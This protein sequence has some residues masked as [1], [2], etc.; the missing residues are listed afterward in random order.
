MKLIAIFLII[1]FSAVYGIYFYTYSAPFSQEQLGQLGDFAGGNLNPILTFISVLALL[2]TISLQTRATELTKDAQELAY[3][4][5]ELTRKESAD[6]Q[7]TIKEQSKLVA[8]QIF[9]SSFFNLIRIGLD[10]Y[11][12]VEI[13]TKKTNLK[14][15]K[16]YDAIENKFQKLKSS[17]QNQ[18]AAFEALDDYNG[19]ICYTAIKNFS[20]VFRFIA[21]N[22]PEDSKEKYTSIALSLL[23]T[24]LMYILCIAKNHTNWAIL[25]S[26]EKCSVFTKKGITDLLD[27]YK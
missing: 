17:G 6:A 4:E 10:E 27:G 14:G 12:S 13:K 2:K 9:E 16:A 3:R 15:A 22:A 24:N 23:P 25:N 21:E 11:N 19:S 1:L 8:I 5:A 18:S 26:Y 20:V 7:K